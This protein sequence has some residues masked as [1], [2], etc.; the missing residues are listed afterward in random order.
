MLINKSQVYNGSKYKGQSIEYC[1]DANKSRNITLI[2]ERGPRKF[3]LPVLG[4]N[5]YFLCNMDAPEG[6]K[7]DYA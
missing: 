5:P 3:K 6:I 1:N 2:G 4:E 7:L